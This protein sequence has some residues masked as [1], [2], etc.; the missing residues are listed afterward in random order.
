MR[1][2]S[3]LNE[4]E[5]FDKY[6][7]PIIEPWEVGKKTTI[8]LDTNKERDEKFEALASAQRGKPETA[9]LRIQKTQ[10]S[11]LY[12]WVAE[13]LGDLTHR[14]SESPAFFRGGFGPV[15]EKV[16]KVLRALTNSYGFRKECLEQAEGNWEYYQKHGRLPFKARNYDEFFGELIRKSKDYANEHKKLKVYNEA[17]QTA[18]DAAIAFG[19]WKFDEAIKLLQ[20]LEKH[21]KKGSEHWAEYALQ[22]K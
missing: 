1:L 17:Q 3:Y 7:N 18:R 11:Q 5:G 22:Y 6:G 16:K 14:M 10:V 12:G 13:H 15:S 21:L 2:R 8:K 9:M 19:N 4:N 20:I